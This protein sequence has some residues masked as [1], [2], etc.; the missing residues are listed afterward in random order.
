MQFPLEQ[1]KIR[2]PRQLKAD[3]EASAKWEK[4][5][6]K[7]DKINE[8]ILKKK[9]DLKNR[10]D[11]INSHPWI[12]FS[13]NWLVIIWREGGEV[14]LKLDVQGQVG[15]RILDVDGQGEWEVL[16]IG[17]L[18]WKSYVVIPKVWRMWKW[19]ASFLVK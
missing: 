19:N 15:R 6:G 9:A 4:V 10:T 18:S 16:K 14:H 2:P 5:K 7:P 1:Q 12:M 8:L 3:S 13:F 11:N 17:Q